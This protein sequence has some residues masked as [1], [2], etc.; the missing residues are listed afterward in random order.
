MYN[1][2]NNIKRLLVQDN[3]YFLVQY[4]RCGIARMMFDIALHNT[5]L[6]QCF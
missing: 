3:L 1:N 2:N 4:T 6:I 5:H